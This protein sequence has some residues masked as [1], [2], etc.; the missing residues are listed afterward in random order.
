MLITAF[1]GSPKGKNSNTHIMVS[2]FLAGAEAAGAKT[3]N[4]FLSQKKIKPCLG[5]IA[6]WTKTPGLCV[7]KDDMPELID[8]FLASDIAVY[9]TPLYVDN[10]TGLMKNFMDRLIPPVDPH[11]VLDE[12]GE[13]CHTDPEGIFPKVAVIS[14][15][16]FPEQS[17]FQVL[18]LL[19]R[20]MAR[21]MQGKLVAEIYRGGGGILPAKKP[22][23]GPLVE[24]YLKLVHKAGEEVV[25]FGRI[26]D[27]TQAA[28]NRPIVPHEMYAA[29]ANRMWDKLLAAAKK[30]DGTDGGD[31]A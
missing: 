3:D 15:C 4:V 26:T 10:V 21:N 18:E 5:C 8:K 29:E 1:N 16:G 31:P 20:R 25:A 7:Q 9:A 11:F 13:M 2:A 24:Q 19:F 27:D 12:H 23:V 17:Q 28:L 22:P 30:D 6:C 14:N